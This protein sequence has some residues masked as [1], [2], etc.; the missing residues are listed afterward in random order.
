MARKYRVPL[1]ANALT[2]EC[3]AGAG[4]VPSRV[5]D[6]GEEMSVGDFRVRPF[7]ISHD[8]ARPVG[9]FICS[10]DAAV[11]SATDTGILTPE[12]RAE[13]GHA[14]L[15]IL[16]S[17]H[18]LEMLRTGPYPWYLKRRIEGDKGHLSNDAAAGFVVDLAERGRPVSVW[19]AHLSRTNNTPCVALAATQYLLWKC[20]GVAMNV[21]VA[22]RDVPSLWWKQGPRQ[23][24]LSLAF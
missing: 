12:I 3:I 6:V 20:L 16:E 14:D 13:A 21:Q 8:A 22:Q 24:K 5:L 18:D 1:I 2:L 9:Y 10:T 15:L 19:L 17:N 7:P 4:C 11:C 23:F